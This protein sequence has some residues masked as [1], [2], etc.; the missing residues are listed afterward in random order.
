M[1]AGRIE[2]VLIVI[3]AFQ[4]VFINNNSSIINLSL[5]QKQKVIVAS[6]SLFVTFFLAFFLIPKYE[7]VG[8]CI[9][10]IIGRLVLT[11]I[12]PI[13]IQKFMG[14]K[15]YT[16]ITKRKFFITLIVLIISIVSSETILIDN[17]LILI[18]ISL[19]IFFIISMMLYQL[20]FNIEQKRLVR[21]RL[22]SLVR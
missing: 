16:I 14:R 15:D 22:I 1:F 5:Q 8:L 3:M 6:V 9:S 18:M 20:G 12:Y 19:L 13:I 2:N 10:L 4:M 7:I 11:I 17:W 21:E